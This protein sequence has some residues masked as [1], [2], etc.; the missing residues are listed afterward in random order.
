MNSF[1]CSF[2]IFS[3][4]MTFK[5]TKNFVQGKGFYLHNN[6]Y[7]LRIKAQNYIPELYKSALTKNLLCGFYVQGAM[8]NICRKEDDE[9][10][11]VCLRNSSIIKSIVNTHIFRRLKSVLQGNNSIISNV[12]FSMKNDCADISRIEEKDS[13]I[14]Y[15]AS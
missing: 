7:S 5:I 2:F 10:E 4:K 6:F 3:F 12:P 8:G 15:S 13:K 9:F 11:D 14:F 1:Y